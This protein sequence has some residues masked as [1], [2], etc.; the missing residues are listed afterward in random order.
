[1]ERRAAAVGKAMIALRGY[2]CEAITLYSD[3]LR[4]RHL[5]R[6]RKSQHADGEN[7]GILFIAFTTIKKLAADGAK[8]I[9]FRLGYLDFLVASCQSFDHRAAL[10]RTNHQNRRV[11]DDRRQSISATMLRRLPGVD[12]ASNGETESSSSI[13]CGNKCASHVGVD[14][15]RSVRRGNR[16]SPQC[17]CPARQH[18]RVAPGS[19]WLRCTGG[20]IRHD[21]ERKFQQAGKR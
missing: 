13:Y 8:A 14:G 3:T 2:H 18:L 4:S 11:R 7:G 15:A 12:I 6:Q 17:A 16:L 21:T 10:L 20:V 5:P 19:L 1:M 9:S